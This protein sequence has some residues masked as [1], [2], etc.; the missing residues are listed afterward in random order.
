MTTGECGPALE[1]TLATLVARA[2]AR[3]AGEPAALTTEGWTTFAELSSAARSV[4]RAL[5]S[6][7]TRR[8]DRVVIALHNRPEIL[9]L[10]HA[11]F[12][13][14]RV[15]VAISARLHPAEV[16]AV[17]VDCD[18]RVIICEPG[19]A[20]ALARGDYPLPLSTTIVAPNPQPPVHVGLEELLRGDPGGSLTYAPVTG[21]D[22][23]ALMYTSGSTGR[24]KGAVITHRAWV[25]MI[26]GVWAAL[27]PVGPG[28]VLLHVAPMSHFSGSVGS[29]YSLRGAAIVTLPKFD[30]K[31][32]LQTVE[33]HRVN[34]L[35]LVPTMLKDLTGC[36]AHGEFDLS[37]LRAVPYGGSAISPAAAAAAYQVFGDVLYQFYGLSEALIPLTVLDERD[38]RPAGSGNPSPL[39]GSAGRVT[40]TVELRVVDSA[41][42][43]RPNGEAGEVEVR[44][45]ALMSGYWNSPEQTSSVMHDGWLRTG[46][47]GRLDGGYLHLIDRRDDV[48]VSGGFNV[49]PSEV[50]RVIETLD[51]VKEVAVV[52]VP[53]QRWGEAV[54]AVVLLDPARTLTEQEVIN[55]CRQ[56]LAG[57]KKP[58]HVVFREQLPKTSTG[59]VHRRALRDQFWADRPRKV[60]E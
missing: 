43:G 38:H 26:S 23:A 54:A 24:P 45:P 11:L 37:A 47:I 60:G 50:E 35:P 49:Y 1:L 39:L 36:A 59:K 32:V 19:H 55:V 18:A 31:T 44:G 58:L 28:D 4:V 9:A 3:Y 8:G 16:A 34:T 27:P 41:G 17:A 33:D 56:H 20:A 15:R 14:G 48:I 7:D 57:Y 25:S 12:A 40:P 22:V 53:D 52:G 42:H 2:H 51:A 5:L 13:S 21:D 29:A 6:F 10:D 46:D 30:P